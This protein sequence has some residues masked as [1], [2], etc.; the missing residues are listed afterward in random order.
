MFRKFIAQKPKPIIKTSI[1]KRT[2]S[3]EKLTLEN[4]QEKAKKRVSKSVNSH[5][6][7]LPR[8]DKYL[9]VWLNRILAGYYLG[10]PV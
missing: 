6:K 1:V 3:G 10:D 8:G 9:M 4:S 5:E 7:P 2:H